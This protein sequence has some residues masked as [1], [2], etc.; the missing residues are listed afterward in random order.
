MFHFFCKSI[1]RVGLWAAAMLLGSAGSTYAD[2]QLPNIFSDSMVLQRDQQNRVWGRADAGEK[3]TVTIGDQSHQTAADGD[4]NW[5]VMLSPLS[6]GDPLEL[7]VKGKNEITIGDVLVG[8]VWIC[9]GQ[10]NMA[11]TVNSSNDADLERAAAHFPQIRMINFPRVGTQS[12]V[13][14]HRTRPGWC[15]RRKR[16]AS[17]RQSV[18]SLDGSSIKR[19]TFRSA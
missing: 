18:T 7:T 8:E 3:V 14:T 16:L 4:G 17:S 19:S 9:S 11:M 10:S 13:W 5:H 6:V 2:V 15:A 1:N 12:P